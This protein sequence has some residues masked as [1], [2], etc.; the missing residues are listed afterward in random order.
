MF[1][2]SFLREDSTMKIRVSC[3]AA[4]A[5]AMLSGQA[6]AQVQHGIVDVIEI[7]G[8]DTAASITAT[9]SG[10]F[11]P[12]TIDSANSTRGDYRLN[13]GTAS[14]NTLGVM[15]PSVYQLERTEPSVATGIYYGIAM[16]GRSG[17]A[18]QI[19]TFKGVSPTNEVNIN[20]AMS[21]FP[22]ADGWLSGHLLNSA[23]NGVMTSV[24]GNVTLRTEATYTGVG[25]EVVDYNIAGSPAGFYLL[26]SDTID[27]RRDGI[28]LAAGGKD[29]N[30]RAS[31]ST[32]Y[33]TGEAYLWCQDMP[34][35]GDAGENDPLAFVFIPEGT[36][37]VTMGTV[38]AAA[39]KL[40]KQ[41]NF[42]VS[43]VGQPLTDGTFRLT[44]DGESP[45]TGT[46]VI[47]PYIRSDRAGGTI[48][49]PVYLQPDG[50]GWLITTRDQPA[51]ALQDLTGWDVAFSFAFLKNGVDIRPGTP[52]KA[53]LERLDEVAAARFAVTE[54][55]PD[56]GNGDM[57]TVRAAG[58]DILDIAGANR[59]D[60]QISF[61]GALLPSIYDN[62]LDTREGFMLGSPSQLIRDNSAT[63]GI[64]G[65]STLS[66][67]NGDAVSHAATPTGGEINSNF[68]LVHFPAARNFLGDS[69]VSVVAGLLQIPVPNG[70]L[71]SNDGVLLAINWDNNNRAVKVT[72]NGA[73]YDNTASEAQNVTINAI[74]YNIGDVATDSVEVGYVYLPYTTP[75]IIA[76]HINAD[77]SALSSRGTFTI[78]AGTDAGFGFPVFELTI[79]GVDARTDGVLLLNAT[80]GAFAMA[81]EPGENGEFEIAGLELV[82]QNPGLCAFTFAYIPYEGFGVGNPCPADFNGDGFVDFFDFDD[83]V[84]CF[85]GTSCPTGTTADFNLDGFIDF[86]DFDDFVVAF[87][88]GC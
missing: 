51:L 74:T 18:Y 27:F 87:E 2:F 24:I 58:N 20:A 65:W 88:A 82:S 1:V 54:F 67:D 44:I 36:A 19:S 13:F 15:I 17:T 68:A 12:W 85:E 11:G 80:D 81:W 73:N 40:F 66:F 38:T 57:D 76:G 83:F 39:K 3:G 5:L 61:L 62:S 35:N 31:W 46:M 25:N 45:A 79:P 43:M 50:D 37:G 63:G 69:D 34:A 41:G 60:N 52:A 8:L 53:Y 23:N 29:E 55:T 48:D 14:D 84:L 72:P 49:N 86:F 78:A 10:G 32:N 30:N 28:L 16:A 59:G 7:D 9:R 42:S 47:S 70:G 33:V 71:A 26:H 22:V 4:L 21:Y 75:G 64:S 56:N 77:G 6:S